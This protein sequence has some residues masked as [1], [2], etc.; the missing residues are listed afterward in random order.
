MIVIGCCLLI[1][2]LLVALGLVIFFSP[3]GFVASITAGDFNGMI[4]S[5]VLVLSFDPSVHG[6]A[7]S[8]SSKTSFSRANSQRFSRASSA[9]NVNRQISR[10][11]ITN[12]T[13]NDSASADT[14]GDLKGSEPSSD[15]EDENGTNLEEIKINDNDKNTTTTQPN[16]GEQK[17]I[18]PVPLITKEE[19]DS[20]SEKGKK[21][22]QESSNKKESPESESEGSGSEEEEESGEESGSNEK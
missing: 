4:I 5:F 9:V 15:S 11:N 16:G 13:Q 12:K 2:S 21:Q 22:V 8:S 10:S 18:V 7:D 19:K 14:G 17:I 6:S 3:S 20:S 1:F